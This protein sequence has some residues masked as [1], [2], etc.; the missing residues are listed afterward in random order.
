MKAATTLAARV[1]EH[2]GE[3]FTTPYGEV[4]R[5]SPTPDRGAAAAVSEFAKLGVLKSRAETIQSI[6]RAYRDGTLPI[7]ASSPTLMID[8]LKMHRGIGD[9]TA[10]Y[11]AMRL[12]HWPDAFPE[13]DLGP[14]KAA[15][16]RK[17]RQLR[18]IAECWRPWRAYA[19]MYMWKSLTDG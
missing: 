10:Q 15:N 1:A 13:S 14:L 3:S 4:S 18:E 16:V 8:Q 17:P 11:V 5:L 2:F 7:R 12:L 9:W 19:A 6:A